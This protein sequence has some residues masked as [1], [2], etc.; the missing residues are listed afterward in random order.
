[1]EKSDP[2]GIEAGKAAQNDAKPGRNNFMQV[3]DFIAE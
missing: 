3:I 2:C 1:M